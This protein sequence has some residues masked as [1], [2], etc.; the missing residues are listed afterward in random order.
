MSFGSILVGLSMALVA[1]AYLAR[2]FRVARNSSDLDR[3]IETWVAQ[4]R[5]AEPEADGVEPVDELVSPAQSTEGDPILFCS[6]CGRR[7][8]P[9]D[10]FCSGCGARLRGGVA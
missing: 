4:V 7:A 10:R 8:G 9:D 1:A 3:M 2:P 5:R 6:Q